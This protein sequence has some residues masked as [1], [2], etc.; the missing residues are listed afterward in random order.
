[1][2]R[3]EY[4]DF[5]LPNVE[6][7]KDYY[8]ELYKERKLP[9]NAIVTRFAPSP[10][11]FVHIGGLFTSFISRKF[12]SQTNGICLLRIEDTDQKREVENGIQQIIEDLKN[13]GIEFDEGAINEREEK[14]E[15]GPYIQSK[16][17][18]IY[19][20]FAKYLIEQDMVAQKD[21]DPILCL[22]AEKG[23]LDIVKCLVERG[24]NGKV[25]DNIT[26]CNIIRKGYLHILKYLAMH[27]LDIHMKN[28]SALCVAALNG[29]FRIVKY[30]IKENA[31]IHTT[32]DFVQ[33][34]KDI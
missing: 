2:T 19:Q 13:Y 4:A 31:N 16:R 9:E 23:Y 32:N 3:K 14:G 5:L 7:T 33:L 6:H 17:K 27:G 22:A 29:K 25:I 12:A 28:D 18:D 26:M 8:E 15:Y 30:L 20:A 11:G 24:S 21:K 34:Q 10:T 1:M